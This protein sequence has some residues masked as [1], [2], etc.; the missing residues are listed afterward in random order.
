MKKCVHRGKYLIYLTKQML[1][2]HLVYNII[3]LTC[4]SLKYVTYFVE[5]NQQISK[6]MT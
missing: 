5:Y 6:V 3:D 1:L 2:D 4:C